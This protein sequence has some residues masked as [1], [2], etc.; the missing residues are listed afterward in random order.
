[1]SRRI[2]Q[3]QVISDKMTKTVVVKVIVRKRHPKYFKQYSVAQRY[4]A[5]DER[6][7]YHTGDVVEIAESRPLSK[8][9]KWVVVRKVK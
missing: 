9:K 4:K 1:M 5:H 2:L 8:E 6:R 3:G 7:E